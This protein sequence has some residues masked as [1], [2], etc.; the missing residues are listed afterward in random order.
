MDRCSSYLPD[1]W[2][3]NKKFLERKMAG[4]ASDVLNLKGLLLRWTHPINSWI[5]VYH[6]RILS[7]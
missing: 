7:H 1:V 3:P 6:V 4:P 2:V 5:V